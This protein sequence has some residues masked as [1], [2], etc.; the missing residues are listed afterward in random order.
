MWGYPSMDTNCFGSRAA[1]Y[2]RRP[3]SKGMRPS[4]GEWAIRTG[5]E[6]SAILATLLNWLRTIQR[7]G[8]QGK[9]CWARSGK[10]AKLL[11]GTGA[12]PGEIDGHGAAERAAAE[13]DPVARH[14]RGGRQ[15]IVGGIGRG[16]AAGLAR[17]STAAAEPGI[18]VGQ[19]R[20]VGLVLP[21]AHR[22]AAPAQIA[23]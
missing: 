8:S 14:V 11:I 7:A 3:C 22:P 23:A 6:H 17:S 19:H 2:S 4:T 12:S 21:A 16:I 18:V 15:P 10:L 20:H 1:S 5:Q 9:R 13:E